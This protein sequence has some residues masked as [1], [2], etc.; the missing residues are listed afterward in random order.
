MPGHPQ[1]SERNADWKSPFILSR[2]QIWHAQ[3]ASCITTAIMKKH[4]ERNLVYFLVPQNV[5]TYS[6]VSV[7]PF[8]N[9]SPRRTAEQSSVLEATSILELQDSRS[10]TPLIN[11]HRSLPNRQFWK[12][13]AAIF[14]I[15]TAVRE[16]ESGLLSVR[17]SEDG[18]S[19]KQEGEGR[20]RQV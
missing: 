5:V 3:I 2:G 10:R 12:R 15:F 16:G 1:P 7:H 13:K 8:R 18:P 17:E 4:H 9:P 11:I 19:E 20:E 6:P 14:L